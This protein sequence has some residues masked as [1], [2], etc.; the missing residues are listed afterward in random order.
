LLA[1]KL[2]ELNAPNGQD[3]LSRC[4]F[5]RWQ[6]PH[7]LYDQESKPWKVEDAEKNL[8]ESSGQWRDWLHGLLSGE[9]CRFRIP[10]ALSTAAGCPD[11]SMSVLITGLGNQ[12]QDKSVEA[13]HASIGSA[14]LK[15][16]TPA[17][18]DS[19]SEAV[20]DLLDPRTSYKG[21][22]LSRFKAKHPLC[23]LRHPDRPLPDVIRAA[24]ADRLPSLE[25]TMWKRSLGDGCP[26]LSS[27]KTEWSSVVDD[28]ARAT[29]AGSPL[30]R[31]AAMI[32]A[33]AS[34]NKKITEL[35]RKASEASA[36]ANGGSPTKPRRSRKK[37]KRVKE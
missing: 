31:R 12:G 20:S 1:T 17:E 13:Y 24:M 19:L 27:L 21:K 32:D 15:K 28:L 11:D 14:I 30:R 26:A 36:N 5:S 10:K 34:L 6:D 7:A 35:V 29:A 37:A 3:G 2:T 4:E 8:P 25:S 9:D 33:Q 18:V 16:S 23:A 22:K